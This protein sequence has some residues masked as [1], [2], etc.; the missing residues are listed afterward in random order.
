MSFKK[1]IKVPYSKYMDD[2]RN[3]C[4]PISYKIIDTTTA[5]L[6]VGFLVKAPPFNNTLDLQD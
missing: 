2:T 3:N 6:R 5:N 4:Q 1:L